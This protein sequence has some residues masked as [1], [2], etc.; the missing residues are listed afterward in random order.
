[1]EPHSLAQLRDD[2]DAYLLRSGDRAGHDL[3]AMHSLALDLIAAYKD[4]IVDLVGSVPEKAIIHLA[5]ARDAADHNE[6]PIVARE[7]DA[8][9][10]V[11]E[12]IV[13]RQGRGLAPAKT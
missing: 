4:A 6:P 8:A 1:M 10:A 2:L 11:V 5:R 13:F 7:L 3:R 12:R 9:M